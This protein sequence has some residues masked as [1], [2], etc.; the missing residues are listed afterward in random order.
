MA[1]CDSRKWLWKEWAVTRATNSHGQ[2][3]K[4][5]GTARTWPSRHMVRSQQRRTVLV[6]YLNYG[7]SE[8]VT[9][10]RF[11]LRQRVERGHQ[12]LSTT[13]KL[14]G[15]SDFKPSPKR[16]V[17]CSPSQPRVAQNSPVRPVMPRTV[18]VR[19]HWCALSLTESRETSADRPIGFDARH[20]SFPDWILQQ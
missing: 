9:C 17:S 1:M 3:A 11:A 14:G 4:V 13:S 8:P 16:R 7:W 2:H 20:S 6:A 19:T 5:G 12:P 15:P 18:P 10:S